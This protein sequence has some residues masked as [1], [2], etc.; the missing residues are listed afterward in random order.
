[1]EELGIYGILWDQDGFGL[2]AV[3]VAATATDATRL[4]QLNPEFSILLG[5]D[6]LGIALPTEKPGVICQE[7]L[8][9]YGGE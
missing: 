3:V 9:V 5:V 4:L 8:N 7:S 2:S 6:K 1:M